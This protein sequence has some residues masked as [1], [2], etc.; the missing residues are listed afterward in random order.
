MRR[1]HLDPNTPPIGCQ[2]DSFLITPSKSQPWYGTRRQGDRFTQQQHHAMIARGLDIPT[3]S[4][5][6]VKR[7]ATS[8][9]RWT[10]L[11]QLPAV[12]AFDCPVIGKRK[13]QVK[14]I[15][16][17]GEVKHVAADGWAHRPYRRPRDDVFS[18]RD[19]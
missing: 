16:P 1:L 5:L 2:P 14:V 3:A 6:L 12:Y 8:M 13:D 7:Q 4:S 9:E 11:G 10:P 15:A 18:G 17:S 19:I